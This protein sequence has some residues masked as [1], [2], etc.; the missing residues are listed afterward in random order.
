[1]VPHVFGYTYFKHAYR[2]KCLSLSTLVF[3]MKK[4]AIILQLDEADYAS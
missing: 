3:M 2:L 4:S 1:M